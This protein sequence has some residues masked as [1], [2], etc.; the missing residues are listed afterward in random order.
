MWVVK[1]GGSL[2]ADGVLKDWL[3]VLACHGRGRV[4]IVP[5]GGPFADQVREAQVIWRFGDPVAHRMALL[6]ME[7]YGLMLA[8][9]CPELTP[10]ESKQTLIGVLRRAGVP[11]WLPISMAAVAEDIPAS[12]D[13]TS[14]SL[15]A[16]LARQ[17]SA[18]RL[19]LVKPFT[20]P[21]A[22]VGAA[23]MSRLG[24]VDRAFPEFVESACFE[25]LVLGKAQL[26]TMQ[27]MLL[28][29]YRT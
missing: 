12:W 1:L 8:G 16:W 6:A 18:E 13:V 5:G 27:L 26:Q 15:A 29:A 21:Q 20:L 22:E 9:I 23:E 2:A 7:Q 25:T 4:V 14:D 19:I 28:G 3:D 10:V 11:V 17:L 24:V